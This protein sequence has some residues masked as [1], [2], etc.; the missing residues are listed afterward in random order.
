M[1]NTE[2]RR[3]REL[4]ACLVA[5][6]PR[7]AGNRHFVRCRLVFI[8]VLSLNHEIVYTFDVVNAVTKILNPVYFMRV[9]Q[10]ANAVADN[11][12]GT[13]API[14][15]ASIQ[16]PKNRDQSS[17]IMVVVVVGQSIQ[18]EGSMHK[19]KKR[20]NE[21]YYFVIICAHKQERGHSEVSS[22]TRE[23]PSLSRL[24]VS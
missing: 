2:G 1:I 9:N 16:N 4:A 13:T 15:I 21:S 22:R 18:G 17:E 20:E 24:F 5:V 12:T 8:S 11:G 7:G 3:T 10:Q 6:A 14:Y 23:R 19:K